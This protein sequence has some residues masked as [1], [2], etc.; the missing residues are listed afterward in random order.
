[1]NIWTNFRPIAWKFKYNMSELS[2]SETAVSD[3]FASADITIT[4]GCSYVRCAVRL[5]S[6]LTGNLYPM[7]SDF[8]IHSHSHTTPNWPYWV[9]DGLLISCHIAYVWWPER[10]PQ[11]FLV[12][13]TN[14]ARSARK[15]NLEVPTHFCSLRHSLSYV[16]RGILSCLHMFPTH[17]YHAVHIAY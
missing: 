7:T 6:I 8:Y 2:V 14:P 10:H 4:Y 9:D 13:S 17:Y 3:S 15:I 12:E 11:G 5:K 1:M 16:G